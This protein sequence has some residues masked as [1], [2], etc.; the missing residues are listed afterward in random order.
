MVKV[1]EFRSQ[2]FQM[3]NKG[4]KVKGMEVGHLHLFTQFMT[5]PHQDVYLEN[6]GK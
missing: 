4:H 6:R 2:D 1:L 3:L 5:N